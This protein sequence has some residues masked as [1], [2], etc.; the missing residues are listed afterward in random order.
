MVLQ[1]Q[2]EIQANLSGNKRP[3]Y[4]GLP[5]IFKSHSDQT[6]PCCSSP[7]CPPYIPS[8]AS[9]CHQLLCMPLW[10]CN[11][12]CEGVLIAPDTQSCD[13][14]PS[15]PQSH[16]TSCD[17]LHRPGLSTQCLTC[18]S[19]SHKTHTC[20]PS[21]SVGDPAGMTD[22]GNDV[23]SKLLHQLQSPLSHQ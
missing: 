19:Q 5:L 14:W 17:L 16:M 21:H 3:G 23:N 4:H 15:H 6:S 13:H 7:S 12:S 11:Q 9:N 8:Y 10:P 2:G 18:V 1:A 22:F 20:V